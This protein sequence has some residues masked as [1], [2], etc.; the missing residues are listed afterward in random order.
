MDFGTGVNW[1][2]KENWGCNAGLEAD[3]GENYYDG[4][5]VHPLE[6]RPVHFL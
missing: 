2:A 4:I 5:T 6:A 3:E 1:V